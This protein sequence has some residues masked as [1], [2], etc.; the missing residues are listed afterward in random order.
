MPSGAPARSHA[1]ERHGADAGR[2]RPGLRAPGR[3]GRRRAGRRG[4]RSSAR[5]CRRW[6]GSR[7]RSC[8]PGSPGTSGKQPVA[9]SPARSIATTTATPSATERMVRAVRSRSRRSGRRMRVRRSFI[10]RSMDCDAA[11]AQAGRGRRRWRRLRRC[12]WPSGRWRRSAW[13]PRGGGRAPGRR[14]RYRDCRWARR[15]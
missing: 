8:R 6:R 10:A 13:R 7:D 12:G 3:S 14:W 4:G 1:V 11:V 5:R 15:R 2:S 9:A